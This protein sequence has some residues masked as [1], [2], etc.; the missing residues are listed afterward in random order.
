M[1]YLFLK[2]RGSKPPPVEQSVPIEPVQVTGPVQPIE[3]PKTE[4]LLEKIDTLSDEYIACA[5]A[6][7]N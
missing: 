2:D 1:L 6:E 3:P 5:M 7:I 4:T